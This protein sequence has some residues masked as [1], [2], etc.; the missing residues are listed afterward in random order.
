MWFVCESMLYNDEFL[1][2]ET[3]FPFGIYNITQFL[4]RIFQINK[5]AGP[6]CLCL[7]II[8]RAFMKRQEIIDLMEEIVNDEYYL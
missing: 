2:P 1:N 7:T 3:V 4:T 5:I 8:S 6:I